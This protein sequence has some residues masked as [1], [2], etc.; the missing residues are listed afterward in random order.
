MEGVVGFNICLILW[1]LVKSIL[2]LLTQLK[3]FKS[4]WSLDPTCN[5]LLWPVKVS[6]PPWKSYVIT[7]MKSRSLEEVAQEAELTANVL[8]QALGVYLREAKVREGGYYEEN[9]CFH[10]LTFLLRLFR[11]QR[12]WFLSLQTQLL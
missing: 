5:G 9:A 12:Q 11:T 6:Q 4:P 2:P 7:L 1:E 8:T 10:L 3:Y